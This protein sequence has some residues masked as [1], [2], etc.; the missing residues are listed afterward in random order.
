MQYGAKSL[1]D[2]LEHVHTIKQLAEFLE[3][4]GCSSCVLS[5]AGRWLE[6]RDWRIEHTVAG[7]RVGYLERGKLTEPLVHSDNEHAAVQRF[8]QTV[9]S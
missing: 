4:H 1:D 8:L 7:W 5:D 2:P 9:A 6:V 3:D